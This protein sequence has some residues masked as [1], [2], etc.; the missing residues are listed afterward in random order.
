MDKKIFLLLVVIFV[1]LIQRLTCSDGDDASVS[2][3]SNMVAESNEETDEGVVSEEEP[4]EG[5]DEEDECE[6]EEPICGPSF[7]VSLVNTCF[8]PTILP[9]GVFLIQKNFNDCSINTVMSFIKFGFTIPVFV[10]LA[11]CLLNAFLSPLPV[12]NRFLISDGSFLPSYNFGLID[13]R[14]LIF[15]DIALSE[16]DFF[17]EWESHLIPYFVI[18]FTVLSLLNR[19]LA[20]IASSIYAAYH[21]MALYYFHTGSSMQALAEDLYIYLNLQARWDYEVLDTFHNHLGVHFEHLENVKSIPK[22]IF[23]CYPILFPLHFLFN[24]GGEGSLFDIHYHSLLP[25]SWHFGST[26]KADNLEGEQDEDEDSL[27]NIEQDNELESENK[28]DHDEDQNKPAVAIPLEEDIFEDSLH[29]EEPY[30]AELPES[31]PN[32]Y[33]D[34][35]VGNEATSSTSYTKQRTHASGSASTITIVTA[36]IAPALLIIL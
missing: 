16:V 7:M 12:L 31:Q 23:A 19:W 36:I 21:I 17:K 8:V 3:E 4:E 32:H 11:Y 30:A 33:T 25:I 34:D 10:K 1:G 26:E 22:K 5:D 20:F 29:G 35:V 6:E 2:E 28:E 14:Q 24:Y 9:L 15:V 27:E 13:L 18:G